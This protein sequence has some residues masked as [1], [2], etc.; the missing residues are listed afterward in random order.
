[1]KTQFSTVYPMGLRRLLADA[2]V[3]AQAPGRVGMRCG[4]QWRMKIGGVG[5]LEAQGYKVTLEA[6]A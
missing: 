6:A 5:K 1:M 2:T 3:Q 4:A